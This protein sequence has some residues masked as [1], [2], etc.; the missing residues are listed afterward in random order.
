MESTDFVVDAF[1]RTGRDLKVIPVQNARAMALQG[2]GHGLQDFDV[3]DSI[4]ILRVPDADLKQRESEFAGN[5][6]MAGWTADTIERIISEH[7]VVKISQIDEYGY[8]W[9]EVWLLVADG[10]TEEHSLMVRL[11]STR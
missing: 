5:A 8:R 3:G 9:Y 10:E 11:R 7:P 1:E 2:V 4:R 6:E